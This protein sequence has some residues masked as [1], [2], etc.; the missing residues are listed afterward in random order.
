MEPYITF[1]DTDN[2]G[3]LQYY[4]LQRRFPHYVAIILG[5]PKEDAIVTS[6]VSGHHLYLSF[7]GTLQGNFIQAIPKVEEEIQAIFDSMSAWFYSKRILPEP[8]KYKKFR[9]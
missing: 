9:I 8:K 5:K 6:A 1:R 7:A 4:I 2:N 3:E